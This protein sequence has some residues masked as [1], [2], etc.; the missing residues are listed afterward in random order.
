MDGYDLVENGI[1]KWRPKKIFLR[2]DPSGPRSRITT[3]QT[4]SILI[5]NR[6]D[7]SLCDVG[8]N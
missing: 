2:S 6:L 8:F 5:C 7:D 1:G 4:I 3:N